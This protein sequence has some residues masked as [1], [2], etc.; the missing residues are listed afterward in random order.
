VAGA[1]RDRGFWIL[2]AAFVAN[3]AALIAP[4]VHLVA[5]LVELGHRPAFAATIAGGLGVL[6]VPA[7]LITTGAQRHWPTTSV[8]ATITLQAAGALALPL[9]GATTV[10][11]VAAVLAFGLGFGV[12]TSH[13]PRSS[14]AAM[15]PMD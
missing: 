1:V 12:A 9:V 13:D 4:S 7:R 2:T 8:V 15:A 6:S 14:Q 11:A 3:T 5:Y 10:G